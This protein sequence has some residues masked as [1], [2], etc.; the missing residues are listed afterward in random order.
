M[1]N[2]QYVP[3]LQNKLTNKTPYQMDIKYVCGG[4]R[5][6]EREKAAQGMTH[7]EYTISSPY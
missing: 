4:M 2:V 7:R 6:R 1:C 3:Y 5:E